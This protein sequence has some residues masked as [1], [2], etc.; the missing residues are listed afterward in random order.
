VLVLWVSHRVRG[1]LPLIELTA[2]L[3]RCGVSVVVNTFAHMSEVLL[4][5]REGDGR[6]HVVVLSARQRPVLRDLLD[7]LTSADAVLVVEGEDGSGY[8]VRGQCSTLT[9]TRVQ[10]ISDVVRY[11]TDLVR[12]R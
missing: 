7:L 2:E 5:S 1:I 9:V 4:R 11:L 6:V 12:G 10:S 8:L 3:R